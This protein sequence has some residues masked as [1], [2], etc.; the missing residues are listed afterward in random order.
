MM[1]NKREHYNNCSID[2]MSAVYGEH[3]E[4]SG[5]DGTPENGYGNLIKLLSEGL[6]I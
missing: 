2:E 5:G 4:E 6:D 3:H 1:I